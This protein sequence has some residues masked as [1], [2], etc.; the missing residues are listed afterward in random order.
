MLLFRSPLSSVLGGNPGAT[1]PQRRRC[2]VKVAR[3]TS[4]FSLPSAEI[5]THFYTY[6]IVCWDRYRW[7]VGGQDVISLCD[8]VKIKV[9][10]ILLL[11]QAVDDTSLN[12]TRVSN[13]SET[14]EEYHDASGIAPSLAPSTPAAEALPSKGALVSSASSAEIRRGVEQTS[15]SV[16]VAIRVR[17]YVTKYCS[18]VWQCSMAL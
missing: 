11:P 3:L 1:L 16:I 14:S 5:P 2:G 4:R 10:C 6:V 17:P 7:T 18:V 13:A 12:D 9:K 15:Q 8:Q